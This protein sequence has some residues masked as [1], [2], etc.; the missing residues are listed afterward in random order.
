MNPR[1]SIILPFYN[2]EKYFDMCL[3]S[4]L[5]QTFRD[6]ELIL[7]NDNSSDNSIK[8][9][10][11]YDDSRI[12]LFSN[13]KNMG[14]SYSLN[15][16][17]SKSKSNFIVRMDADDV[18]K[19]ERLQVQ[20]D[21]ISS[22]MSEYDIIGTQVGIINGSYYNRYHYPS[23]MQSAIDFSLFANPLSHPSIIGKKFFFIK[24]RYS[25]DSCYEGFED[26]ELWSRAIEKGYKIISLEDKL[27]NYRIHNSQISS[28]ISSKFIKNLEKFKIKHYKRIS[29]LVSPPILDIAIKR[30]ELGLYN[31]Y[32]AY[33]KYNELHLDKEVSRLYALN[34]INNSKAI[35]K[36][37]K[38]IIYNM[39]R[40]F[41]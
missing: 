24:N 2:A 36:L 23:S 29:E 34:L 7:I 9:I 18:C 16:G 5:S 15:Y 38:K 40:F 31:I 6:F 19:K 35:N 37:N 10:E 25:E 13:K 28:N 20:Y 39:V 14:V 8:I 1:V 3:K 4:I 30:H 17:V 11:N 22:S 41:L 21:A 27:L 32:K 26:Y 12:R 33:R